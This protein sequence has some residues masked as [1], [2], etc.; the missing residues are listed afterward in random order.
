M[1]TIISDRF[2]CRRR[3]AASWTSLNEVLYKGEIGVETDT[4]RIK[5]GD[6]VSAW[7]D[8][9]YA[10]IGL[11]DPS[12]IADGDTLS[13][14]ASAG[15]WVPGSVSLGAS[16]VS[17]I[18]AGG[19]FTGTDVESALQQLGAGGGGSG[20]M[21]FVGTATV[22]GAAASTLTL[23]GL[24]LD[25][26]GHYQIQFSFG[27]ATASNATLSMYFNSDF[28]ATNYDAQSYTSAGGTTPSARSNNG[29]FCTME[30]SETAT[31]TIWT[32]K[33]FN[34]RPRSMIQAVRAA[35]SVINFQQVGH[36]WTT[37]G[38]NVTGITISSSVANALA[39]GSFFK[40]YKVN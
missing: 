37:A 10:S 7:N 2:A 40:V 18:D 14:D 15:C 9:L 27:N 34:G 31:G 33:D 39:V 22:A 19:Y 25:T 28:T 21:T 17:I 8:L 12:G 24:N 38:T 11:F 16:S 4:G 30:A 23:S 32:R 3:T 26:A 20:A 13:W 35:P 5:I 6:G 1:T 36:V 29:L